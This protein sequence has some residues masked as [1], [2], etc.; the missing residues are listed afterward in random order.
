MQGWGTREKEA[1]ARQGWRNCKQQC[2][3]TRDKEKLK[4]VSESI[5]NHTRQK[6]SEEK[7]SEK[8]YHN[9]RKINR[10]GNWKT[11]SNNRKRILALTWLGKGQ[12]VG[13]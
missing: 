6:K 8:I 5:G 3:K 9:M 11:N 2:W 12:G 7:E 1:G 10:K 13:Y 4:W